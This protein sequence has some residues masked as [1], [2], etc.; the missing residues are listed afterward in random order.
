MKI[1]TTEDELSGLIQTGSKNSDVIGLVPTLGCLHQGHKRLMKRASG[2]CNKV[3]ATV[4]VN[5]LQFRRD[6]FENYPRNH[7]QDIGIA[8]EAGIDILFMPELET[9]YPYMRSET[10]F[11]DWQDLL[12]RREESDFFSELVQGHQIIR[13]P[14]KLVM[15]LDGKLHP[16][17]FDGV[18]TVVH[19][20]FEIIRPDRA[21]FGEKDLQ[22]IT[23]IERLSG[24]YFP[25]LKICRVETLRETDGLPFSSRNTLLNKAE[26]TQALNISLALQACVKRIEN[27]EKSTETLVRYMK[28]KIA[29]QG[30]IELDY[31]SIVDSFDL[32]EVIHIE[33]N[34]VL[35]IAFFVNG[36]RL[37][38]SIEFKF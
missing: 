26:R 23:I 3:I 37:A 35:Y 6:K 2:E 21:Y 18:S 15:K 16:W 32:S 14:S 7:D 9:I 24:Q 34:V 11:F 4:F 8:N 5:P 25:N 29:T 12:A 33:S 17:H 13:A 36:I 10:N 19:R 20:L 28:E 27:G 38:D 22:Q 31:F 1:C 30:D